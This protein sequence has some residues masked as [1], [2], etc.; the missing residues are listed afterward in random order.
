VLYPLTVCTLALLLWS[1]V[2][3]PVRGQGQVVN[4][5]RTAA[6][7]GQVRGRIRLLLKGLGGSGFSVDFPPKK[8]YPGGCGCS[9]WLF[10]P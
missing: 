4:N 2:M 10:F 3:Q 1:Y 9:L 5:V 8:L 6:F 7:T